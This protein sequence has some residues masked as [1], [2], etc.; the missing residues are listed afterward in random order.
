MTSLLRTIFRL[1]VYVYRWRLGWLFGHRFL[2][3]VHVG[4]RTGRR[5]ETVLEVLEYRKAPREAVVMSG[6]GRNANWLRNISAGRCVQVAIG[7]D[8]FTATHRVLETGEAASVV[9]AYEQRHRLLTPLIR[10]VLSRLLGWQYH[11]DD[12]E[13]RRL[14]AQLPLIGFRPAS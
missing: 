10:L 13:R 14:V 1:P 8:R 11:G 4:R 3:L 2:L 9:S 12:R 6:F 5:H 7:A